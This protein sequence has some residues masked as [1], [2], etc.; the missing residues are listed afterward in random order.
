MANLTIT[1]ASVGVASLAPVANGDLNLELITMG[2]TVT[3]GV[4]VYRDL[5]ASSK[6]IAADASTTITA[7]VVGITLFGGVDTGIGLMAT[8]GQIIL[9]ATLVA[10]TA[11]YLSETAGSICLFSDLGAGAKVVKL[12]IARSTTILDVQIEDLGGAV[13]AVA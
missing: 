10:G 11:Y 7:L 8:K 4:P 1:D 12:G 2:A 6:L 9:G 13:V 3:K 5:T